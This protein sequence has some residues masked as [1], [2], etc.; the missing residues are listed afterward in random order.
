MSAAYQTVGLTTAEIEI[1]A[2]AQK[3]RDYYYRSVKGRR[4]F[5]LG[6]GPAALAFVGRVE[7]SRPAVSRRAR[8]DA[9]PARVR[10]RDARAPRRP[11]DGASDAAPDR[12]GDEPQRLGR[13]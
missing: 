5:Q 13:R 6:L 8:R 7:R 3:K 12:G 4:L 2:K 9:R 10:A 1:L 11:V